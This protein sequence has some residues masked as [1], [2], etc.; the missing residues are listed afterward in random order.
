MRNKGEMFNFRLSYCQSYQIAVIYGG[1]LELTCLEE[2]CW[3]FANIN[4]TTRGDIPVQGFLS[5]Q[6]RGRKGAD[7]N[8]WLDG[9]YY[10]RALL[11]LSL[12][13]ETTLRDFIDLNAS[14]RCIRV[15]ELL[16]GGAPS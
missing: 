8:F 15:N 16:K 7:A 9:T 14:N 11:R 6:L 4:Q 5:Q 1:G 12:A 10:P 3:T 13:T 2:G